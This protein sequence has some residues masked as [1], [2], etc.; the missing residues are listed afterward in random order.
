MKRVTGIMLIILGC[1]AGCTKKPSAQHVNH[2]EQFKIPVSSIRALPID[3]CKSLRVLGEIKAAD[4]VAIHPKVNGKLAEYAVK[5]GTE[6]KKGD[7]IAYIDRDE[8]GYTY[9]KAPILS[10]IFGVVSTLPLDE[11]SAVWPDTAIA[12][13]MNIDRVKAVFALPERYRSAV[14]VGQKVDIHIDA[15]NQSHVAEI[16]EIDP[17]IDPSTHAFKLKVKIDN[18]NKELIPGMFASGDIIL[19]TFADSIMVPEEAIVALKGE[20]YIYKVASELATL[21][22]VKLGLRKEGKVQILE[23]VAAGDLVIIG[24]NHKVS[25][26]KMVKNKIL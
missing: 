16:S 20:W 5:S 6:I 2:E 1:L 18:P 17:H 9:N 26:G 13:I 8:V 10:P 19:K 12:Y 3:V 23:G 21:Q 7:I 11:G 14:E 22:K 24:G 25:D 15:L 4:S